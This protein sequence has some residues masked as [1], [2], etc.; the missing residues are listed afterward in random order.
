[1]PSNTWHSR[2]PASMEGA[3]LNA[4]LATSVALITLT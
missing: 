3:F 4:L 1:M 2:N